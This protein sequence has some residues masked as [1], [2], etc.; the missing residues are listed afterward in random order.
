MVSNI[1]ARYVQKYMTKQEKDKELEVMF[2]TSK[3]NA[4]VLYHAISMAGQ[5]ESGIKTD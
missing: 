3:N 2:D 5:T 4:F 1:Q